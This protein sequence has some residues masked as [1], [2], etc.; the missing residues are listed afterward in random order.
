MKFILPLIL[1]ISTALAEIKVSSTGYVTTNADTALIYFMLQEKNRSISEASAILDSRIKEM[2]SQLKAVLATCATQLVKEEIEVAD[3]YSVR[4]GCEQDYALTRSMVLYCTGDLSHVK[5]LLGILFQSGGAVVPTPYQETVVYG[6][7]DSATAIMSAYEQALKESRARATEIAVRSG[8]QL[9]RLKAV[10]HTVLSTD[11]R[12]LYWGNGA[13]L[14]FFESNRE[15]KV[16]ATGT[17]LFTF[18][19]D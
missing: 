1:C 9:G 8:L 16:V 12:G 17:W 4:I 19:T 14:P 13:R 6:L 10:E 18:E 11:T 7:R 15:D 2:E 3:R 5:R